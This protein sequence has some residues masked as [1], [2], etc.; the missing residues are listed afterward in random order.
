MFI[1]LLFVRLCYQNRNRFN[2]LEVKNPGVDLLKKIIRDKSMTKEEEQ[3]LLI[4]LFTL[5]PSIWPITEQYQ[6]F[7]CIMCCLQS[8]RG[9]K[10]I[11]NLA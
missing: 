9:M 11:N 1:S 7:S 2:Y 5:W 6:L 3:L 8:L 4:Q 10:R